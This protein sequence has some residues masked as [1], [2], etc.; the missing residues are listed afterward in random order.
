MSVVSPQ[1]KS[2]S[3]QSHKNRPY[4]CTDDTLFDGTDYVGPTR[5]STLARGNSSAWRRVHVQI[6]NSPSRM[7]LDLRTP[8][9]R[10]D[11]RLNGRQRVLSK[12]TVSLCSSWGSGIVRK[13]LAPGK[14]HFYARFRPG[15]PRQRLVSTSLRPVFMEFSESF[16]LS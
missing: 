1:F 2:V 14:W 12:I 10:P 9:N 11:F 6:S 16:H 4:A 5:G 15:W 8:G 13:N 3:E 7:G